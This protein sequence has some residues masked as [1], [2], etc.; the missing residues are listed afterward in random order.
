MYV[1]ISKQQ[2][3]CFATQGHVDH[4][5]SDGLRLF[6]FLLSCCLFMI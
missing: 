1:F 3:I 5:W 6:P 2:Q 4:V